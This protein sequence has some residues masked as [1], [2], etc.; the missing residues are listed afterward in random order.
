MLD[1]ALEALAGLF[2]PERLGWL[3]LGVLVGLVV[4]LIP[5]LGGVAGMSLLLPFVYGMDPHSAMALMIGI[6]AANHTSD[7]FP[8]VLVGVPGSAGA[9]ATVMDG[10]PLAKQGQAGRALGASFTASML[11]GIFGAAVLFAV[12][13]LFRPLILAFGS[14]ELFMLTMLGI[15]TVAILARGAVAKGLL[16][17]LFGM[18]LSTV[19]SAPASPDYR[20]TFGSPYLTDGLPIAMVA[21]AI[22]AIPEF[23]DLL[24]RNK[25]I[26]DVTARITAG[27]LEG[28]RDT[29]RHPGLVLRSSGLG[30]LLGAIPGV[31]GSAIN[32]IVY[33][34]TARLS[35]D[36]SRFGKGDIRGV[37]APE[38]ANNSMEGGQLIPALMFGIPGSGVTA[39]L[40]GG[41]IL[42]GIQPGPEL[43]SDA[44]LPVVLTIVW[45]LVVANILAT[46][47]CFSLR[48][49]VAKLCL[50]PGRRLV[51]F[52]FVAVALA[53]YQ[54]TQTWADIA[55]LLILGLFGWFAV[56]SG[57]SRA[58]FVVGFVLGPPAERYLWIS[59][60]RYDLSWL[61]R[62]GV[63]LIAVAI[64]G[65]LLAGSLRKERPPVRDEV[66]VSAR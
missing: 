64:L 17:A 1:I 21:M 12:L 26:S 39:V 48:N 24:R 4:G 13:P 33:G 52:L 28:A 50:I 41:L 46:A 57:W 65:V 20:Y 38:A 25:P 62:P 18:L 32:W 60:A 61:V 16:A 51:P 44:N 2:T 31:G 22:F 15:S 7:T 11:G 10:Y 5:G 35:K 58:A 34:L 63:I 54:T 29:L 8:A 9:G 27:R 6:M 47:I 53:V 36:R 45:S 40:L 59:M 37:I 43:V 42:V 14:P 23:V 49:F 55:M 30:A 56:H 66:L 3:L 19:G